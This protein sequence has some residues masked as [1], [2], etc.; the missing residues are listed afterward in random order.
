MLAKWEIDS[1]GMRHC[2]V[3]RNELPRNSSTKHACTLPRERGRP[4]RPPNTQNR[5]PSNST[6]ATP[7]GAAHS[8]PS[9]TA[10]SAR[11]T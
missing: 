3:F 4:S 7:A 11:S 5:A 6:S 9:A 1:A 8:A 2:F 10:H